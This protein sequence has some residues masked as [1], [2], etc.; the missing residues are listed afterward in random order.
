MEKTYQIITD[1]TADLNAELMQESGLEMLPMDVEIEGKR[2]SYAP[3]GGDL[4]EAEFYRALQAG[5]RASTSQINPL[6]YE[7][8]FERFLK[9]G[10]EELRERYPER[11]LICVDSLCASAGEGLLARRA[12]KMQR[13]GHSLEET[14]AW[15]EEN[16]LH[17]CHWF[18][19]DDLQHLRRGG[20]ISAATAIVGTA[21]QVKPILRVDETGHLENV[22]KVRGRRRALSAL[23]ERFDETWAPELDGTVMLGHGACLEDAEF[24]AGQLR[25]RHPGIEIDIVYMGPIIGAHT[26]PGTVALLYWG[27]K[28]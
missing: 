1:A 22:D 7:S 14:A 21:L 12:A 28:R 20:R 18:T 23:V 19:V 4:G 15:L 10:M 16:R 25:E 6:V 11:K 9:A 13:E 8:C 24:V 27:S 26:G 2:Y 17:V 3:V 5:K